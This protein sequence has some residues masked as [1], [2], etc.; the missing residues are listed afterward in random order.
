LPVRVQALIIREMLDPKNNSDSDAGF[1]DDLRILALAA[2]GYWAPQI[3]EELEIS[4]ESVDEHV[5]TMLGRL[6]LEGWLGLWREKAGTP[7]GP[8]VP[9]GPEQERDACQGSLKALGAAHSSSS[10]RTS[11]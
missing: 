7:D 9:Q 6:G 4:Q 2:Q 1:G 10:S 3:A 5:E 8:I 11:R